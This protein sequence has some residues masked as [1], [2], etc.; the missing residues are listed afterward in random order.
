YYGY[1]RA[2]QLGFSRIAL[3]SDPFQTKLLKGFIRK[4]VS[5]DI[6][7]IPMVTDTLKMLEPT[8]LDPEIPFENAFKPDFISIK[9]RD[10]FWKRMR[11]TLRGN[12]DTTAY[13]AGK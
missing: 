11:G 12:M 9:K 8:M 6:A 5:P 4:K 3:A 10:S 1:R 13:E 7:L 2:R